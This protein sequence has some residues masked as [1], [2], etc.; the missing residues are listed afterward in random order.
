M[1][2]VV[3]FII[4]VIIF[5]VN[6]NATTYYFMHDP[7][8][9]ADHSDPNDWANPLNWVNSSMQRVNLVPTILDQAN[10]CYEPN[11]PCNVTT[12]ASIKYLYGFSTGQ[13][14]VTNGATLT[15]NRQWYYPLAKDSNVMG[16]IS[17]AIGVADI[18]EGST[19]N[20][21]A[22][23]Y[24]EAMSVG[25]V[26]NGIL[27]VK[28]T[29]TGL[30]PN[31]NWMYI[32]YGSM[33]TETGVVIPSSGTVNVSGNGCISGYHRFYIGNLAGEESGTLN[34]LDANSTVSC[35]QLYVGNGGHGT[36]NVHDGLLTCQNMIVPWG[37]SHPYTGEQFA[38]GTVT[39]S[40]NGR[41]V[42][43]GASNLPDLPSGY[44][45]GNFTMCATTSTGGSSYRSTLN[46]MDANSILDCNGLMA[47]EGGPAT[48]NMNGG[49]LECNTLYLT[50]PDSSKGVSSCL[51]NLFGG[52]INVKKNWQ[53]GVNSLRYGVD[54]VYVDIRNHG[55]LV[56]PYSQYD[57]ITHDI[58]LGIIEAYGGTGRIITVTDSGANTCTLTACASVWP[59]QGDVNNDCMV[60]FY[61]IQQLAVSWL[62]SSGQADLNNDGRVNF[63]DFALIAGNWLY[64]TN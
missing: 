5:A 14:T 21:G 31:Y 39:I 61:D 1:K 16:V 63:K 29:L 51:I 57:Q 28:G 17:P 41:I 60:D 64:G 15:V 44:L 37:L 3:S 12:D 40:G 22:N 19:V 34:I 58:D 36:V 27:N 2:I 62:N 18:N 23:N 7:D 52:T 26:G 47:G 4:F 24:T 56:V 11:F 45:L 10:Y 6:C 49:T 55:K 35:H 9:I 38:Q 43:G 48:I 8:Y 20:V 25:H 32:A 13:M 30:S 54:N 33:D 53:P 59:V 46:I 42:I 50:Y